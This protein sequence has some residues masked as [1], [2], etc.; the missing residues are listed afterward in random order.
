M[1]LSSIPLRSTA[2]CSTTEKEH[3]ESETTVY[4]N[5]GNITD[6]EQIRQITQALN[7]WDTA[8][9]SNNSRVRFVTDQ[10]PPSGAATLSFQNGTSSGSNAAHT[11]TV[12]RYGAVYDSIQSATITFYTQ[13]RTPG[14]A[15]IYNSNASGYDTIFRKIALHEIGHTMGL[16][17]A[18]VPTNPD[19]SSNYCGQTDGATVMNG[20]CETNDQGGNYPIEIPACD[21]DNVNAQFDPPPPSPTPPSCPD[22]AVQQSYCEG[23]GG[24]WF[25]A[26]CYCQGM[27]VNK[28]YDPACASCMNNGG[29]WCVGG[30]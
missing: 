9:G 2:Q 5:F 13:G 15:P 26:G 10:P 28:D 23:R 4:V 17:E 18:P 11:D 19:G 7:S 27:E 1:A 24:Y 25:H 14:G 20:Y 16:D 21:L 3:W 30:S 29:A 8:N 6:P 22:E 12:V